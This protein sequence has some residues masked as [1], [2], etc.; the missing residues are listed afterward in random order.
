MIK[1]TSSDDYE[2]L[3][4]LEQECFPTEAWTFDQIKSHHQLQNS[5][6]YFREDKSLEPIGYLI[7]LENSYE[8]EILRIGVVADFR[9]NGIA[10][11]LLDFL[12][13]LRKKRE[14]L[15]EVKSENF[16]AIGLYQKKGF[17]NFAVRKRYYPDGK[18][19]ILMKKES[20]N[21]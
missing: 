20:I 6:L 15:L 11:Q 14:I 18:D 9:R 4:K 12:E 7:Y 2:V 1:K 13:S 21:D 10:N 19:A 8:I 16:A 5:L 17:I 3:T